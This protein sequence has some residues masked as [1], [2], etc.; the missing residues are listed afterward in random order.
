MLGIV[1]IIPFRI[2][3]W[4][5]ALA[6]VFVTLLS[7]PMVYAHAW[8]VKFSNAINSEVN[9]K[10]LIPPIIIGAIVLLIFQLVL[11]KGVVV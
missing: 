10:I 3:P 9:R 7:I 1:L 2:M 8:K 4:D 5:R 6:L 11:A